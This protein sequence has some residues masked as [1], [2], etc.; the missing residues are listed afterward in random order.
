M[1]TDSCIPF[2]ATAIV[3]RC[4][5]QKFIGNFKSLRLGYDIEIES[6]SSGK[7]MKFILTSKKSQVFLLES[8]HLKTLLLWWKKE[9]SVEEESSKIKKITSEEA[10]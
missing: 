1:N 7:F 6:I 9:F 5:K 4:D 8:T 3:H 2:E 10:S